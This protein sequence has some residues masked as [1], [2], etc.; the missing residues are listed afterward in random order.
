MDL[1]VYLHFPFCAKHCPYCDFVVIQGRD[2][3]DY[4]DYL[5][6]DL[7][8]GLSGIPGGG[9]PTGRGVSTVYFGGGTPS[10]MPAGAIARLLDV[11]D[12]AARQKALPYTD[13]VGQPFLGCR[14]DYEITLEANPEDIAAD[15]LRSW[16]SEGITRLSVGIQSF[17]DD[18]LKS[19]GRLHTS[20]QV[21]QAC[22]LALSAGFPSVNFDLIFGKPGETLA[23]WE[24]ELDILLQFSPPH[25]SLYALELSEN[26]KQR[27]RRVTH[28]SLQEPGEEDIVAMYRLA[29]DQLM[30]A[31]YWWYEVSNYAKPGHESRHNIAYW[32]GVPYLGVGLG[33][34]SFLNG[35]RF[36]RQRNLTRYKAALDQ[37]EVPL[38]IGYQLSTGRAAFEQLI[39]RFRYREPFDPGAL[40]HP[41][42]GVP[43][44]SIPELND[45]LAACVSKL[46]AAGHLASE[47]GRVMLTPGAMEISNAVLSEFLPLTG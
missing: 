28:A 25:V 45:T 34:H 17:R 23:D 5:E 18:R 20:D 6:K 46:V 29:R 40:I 41:Q 37:G 4:V 9:A 31:G 22:D 26:G 2:S 36:E 43:L 8:L 11:I 10:L 14:S 47:N 35:E 42:L 12:K 44:R 3:G 7:R 39:V 30:G 33:A 27:M 38:R 21:K 32:T 24:G 19:L 16:K 1:A 15:V 13:S